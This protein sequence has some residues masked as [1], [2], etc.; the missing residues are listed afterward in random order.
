MHL[1]HTTLQQFGPA[2]SAEEFLDLQSQLG[3]KRILRLF[4]SRDRIMS[5][6]AKAKFVEP[7]LTALPKP[8]TR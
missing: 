4:Y 1:V 8:P 6:E 2:G 5:A 3:N 7:D